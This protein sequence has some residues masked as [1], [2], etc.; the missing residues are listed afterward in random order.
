MPDYNW[1]ASINVDQGLQQAPDDQG[2]PPL[3]VV[4]AKG[5]WKNFHLASIHSGFLI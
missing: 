1:S 2:Q 5:K 4:S 3:S